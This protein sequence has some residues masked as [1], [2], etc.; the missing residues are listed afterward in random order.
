MFQKTVLFT[1]ICIAIFSCSPKKAEVK[2]A[3]NPEATYF[4]IAQFTVDQWNTY[5]GQP[6]GIEK[7]TYIDGKTDSTLLD[8]YSMDWAAVFKVFFA[9]DISDP[10]FLGKY[11]FTMFEDNATSTRN[12]YYEAKDKELFTRKFQIS[13]DQFTDKVRS[14]YIETEKKT[15]WST[16][17][18]KLLYMPLKV[19]S[20]QEFEW[21]T[22]GEPKE[23]RVEYRFL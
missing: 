8:A 17:T 9:T 16:V 7:T 2:P 21:S 3:G 1:V 4:S 23:M 14:I 19:I 13:A 18:Q 6:Y 11:D 5:H 12:F 15:R 20:I 10:K 22:G